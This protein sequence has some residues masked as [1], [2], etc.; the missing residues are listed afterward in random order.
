M[1]ATIHVNELIPLLQIAISPV[2]LISGVGLLLLSMTNRFGR[3]I[4]RSRFLWGELGNEPAGNRASIHAQLE[5]LMRRAKLIRLAII[6]ASTSVLGA[7]VLVIV[8]FGAV[9]LGIDLAWLVIL[10]FIGCLL[11]LVPSLIVFIKDVNQS[12]IALKILRGAE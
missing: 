8:L 11:S 6:L 7:A 5:V 4:D 3:V 1:M 2:I 12:L 10:L 9:W